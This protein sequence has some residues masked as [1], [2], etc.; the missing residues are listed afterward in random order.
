MPRHYSARTF[1]RNTPNRLLREY[2]EQRR[3]ELPPP[4][5]WNMIHETD[6]E[7]ILCFALE[8]LPV[9]TRSAVDGDFRQV[10]ALACKRG[11]LSILEEAGRRGLNLAE[12][13]ASLRNHYARAM[14]TLLNDPDC[15][16]LAGTLH[17]MDCCGGWR[18]RFVGRRL[19]V[20]CDRKVL[21]LFESKVQ[22]FYRRQGRGRFCHVDSYQRSDP[23]RYCFFVF[24]EDYASTELGFGRDGEFLQRTRRPAFELIFVYRPEEGVLELAGEGKVAQV[25]QLM[26]MFCTTVLGLLD[27]PP[28]GVVP[29]DL[30]VLKDR[31]FP[32][33]T[34]PADGVSAV[35]VRLLR[36]DLG[37]GARRITVAASAGPQAPHAVYD[38]VD[39]TVRKSRLNLQEMHVSQARLQFVFANGI[40]PKSLTF[41]VTYPDRCTLRDDPCDQIAKRCL[42]RWG[43]ARD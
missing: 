10:Y 16:R 3:I 25:E 2:F 17:E 23:D 11:V 36:F 27:L 26:R 37:G 41:D 31:T 8:K 42:K 1:L 21:A 5:A 19:E 18:R 29:F 13:F 30:T 7:R 38:L 40:G 22:L 20:S 4:F 6:A 24:P 28:N 9:S 14:W 33:A 32:F 39:E 15:F 34:E 43:I 12:Q 35:H